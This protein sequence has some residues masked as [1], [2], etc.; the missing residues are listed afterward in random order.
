MSHPV[1]LCLFENPALSNSVSDRDTDL[2]THKIQIAELTKQ[3]D[4][5]KNELEHATKNKNL[6]NVSDTTQ[7]ETLMEQNN[8]LKDELAKSKTEKSELDWENKKLIADLTTF[9]NKSIDSDSRG[10]VYAL[11]IFRMMYYGKEFDFG[12]LID[13][14]LIDCKNESTSDIEQG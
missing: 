9:K 1:R 12:S 3:T 4:H 6:I 13:K 5:L 8:H 7:I 10:Y 11:T 14:F 2:A